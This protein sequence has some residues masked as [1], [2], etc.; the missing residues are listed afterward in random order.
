VTSKPP[1]YEQ[2]RRL[3]GQDRPA[4]THPISRHTRHCLI[5]LPLYDIDMYCTLDL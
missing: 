4:V 5:T 3:P 1:M 2:A